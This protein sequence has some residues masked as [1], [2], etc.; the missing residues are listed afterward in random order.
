MEIDCVDMSSS[1]FVDPPRSGVLMSRASSG[2]PQANSAVAKGPRG[3][4][5]KGG[6]M[7]WSVTGVVTGRRWCPLPQKPKLLGGTVIAISSRPTAGP[8]CHGRL[9]V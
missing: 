7:L 6:R 8:L 9:L 4:C 5:K 3:W 2:R 1:S